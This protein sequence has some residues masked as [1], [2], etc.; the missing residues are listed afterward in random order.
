MLSPTFLTPRPESAPLTL[1]S[2]APP[3]GTSTP[4]NMTP[5]SEAASEEVRYNLNDSSSSSSEVPGE[6]NDGHYHSEEKLENNLKANG[7]S[8]WFY[9]SLYSTTHL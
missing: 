6:A 3:L 9:F 1:E 2:S 8:K 4:S 7:K 5:L